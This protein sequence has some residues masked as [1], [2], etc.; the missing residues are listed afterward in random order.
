[1]SSQTGTFNNLRKKKNQRNAKRDKLKKPLKMVAV[2]Y[3]WKKNNRDRRAMSG[4]VVLVAA[5]DCRQKKR[6]GGHTPR[7]E[8]VKN[9]PK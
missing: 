9:V 3:K 5:P 7:L 6:R 4:S 8:T 1:L 2:N